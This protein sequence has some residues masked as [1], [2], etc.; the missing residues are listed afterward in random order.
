MNVIF[1][2]KTGNRIPVRGKVGDRVLY[3]AQRYGVEME[4]TNSISV[5]MYLRK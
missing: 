3:L 4:G 5:V 2:D 1:I